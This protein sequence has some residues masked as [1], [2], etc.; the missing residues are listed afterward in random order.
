RVSESSTTIHA[1][2]ATGKTL[3][4]FHGSHLSHVLERMATET[5]RR[6]VRRHMLSA[7]T[8]NAA[9][10]PA[11][12]TRAISSNAIEQRRFHPTNLRN[13]STM[14]FTD[15]SILS[16]LLLLA[17]SSTVLGCVNS[18]GCDQQSHER[19]WIC[20]PFPGRCVVSIDPLQD[21]VAM[22]WAFDGL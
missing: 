22:E 1:R 16:T 4:E 8:Y 17:F 11:S 20:P 19:C 12:H 3:Y 18:Y 2:L 7:T 14:R 9:D 5:W 6:Q 10:A 15:F 21:A 13:I